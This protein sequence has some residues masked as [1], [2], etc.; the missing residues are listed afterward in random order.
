MLNGLIA[1]FWGQLA[2]WHSAMA[3]WHMDRCRHAA[4]RR[5]PR[6]DSMR[7]QMARARRARDTTP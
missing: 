1:L 6:W 3:I 4:L 5:K 2:V 7:A